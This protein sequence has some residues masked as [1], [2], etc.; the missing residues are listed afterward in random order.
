MNRV[1]AEVADEVAGHIG[2]GRVANYIPALA[3]V[4]PRQFGIAV[5]LPDG[6]SYGVGDWLTPF[7]MQS[8]SKLFTLSL[9]LA[10]DNSVWSR[11]GREP[12]GSA[13]NSLVQLEYENGLPRN[14]FIN[15]GALVVTDHLAGH[16]GDAADAVLQFLRTE[17]GNAVIEF[18]QAVVESEASHSQRN[19]AL[20]H[21]LASYGNLHGDPH[22]I[23][24]QYIRHCA[25][26]IS[27]R[28]LALAGLFL[29]C[30]GA[31]RDGSQGPSARQTKRINAVMLT[32]GTYDAAGEFAYRVGLPGKSGV[33]GGI[34]A[35][36]PGRCSIAV[37][38]PGLDERG[39]SVA[40]VAALDAFTTKTG[41]SV[42]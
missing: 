16:V 1:L 42:F 34:L 35:I 4:D 32:C 17:S 25:I 2:E 29:A 3:S 9:A 14:P 27:C 37:W 8:I 22:N 15:A 20:A 5:A 30:H 21:F 39:N 28:D 18:D 26:A 19:L 13:F 11:V 7:S 31:L 6:T 41:W 38:G 40:G 36:C 23:V 12:S 10:S 24:D 33:G